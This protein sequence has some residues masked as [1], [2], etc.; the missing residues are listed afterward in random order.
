MASAKEHATTLEA[1]QRR[2][3]EGGEW[4]D[5]D[6]LERHVCG[7]LTSIVDDKE[8]YQGRDMDPRYRKVYGALCEL[9]GAVQRAK[10]A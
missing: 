7:A 9:R 4:Q 10:A 8:A 2:L 3:R 6:R 5:M 1:L